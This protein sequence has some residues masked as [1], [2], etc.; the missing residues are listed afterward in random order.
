MTDTQVHGITVFWTHGING[1]K[2]LMMHFR[3]RKISDGLHSVLKGGHISSSIEKN[4]WDSMLPLL[5]FGCKNVSSIV[6]ETC[7]RLG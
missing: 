6:K 3:G 4:L 5:M 1:Y 7:L 2:M